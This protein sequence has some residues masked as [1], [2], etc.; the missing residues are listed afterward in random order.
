MPAA[1]ILHAEKG[2]DSNAIREQVR[3]CGAFANI[4]PKANRKW[5]NCFSPFLYKDRNAIERMFCRIKDFRRI[6]TRYDRLARNF[7][8]AGG[9]LAEAAATTANKRPGYGVCAIHDVTIS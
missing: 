4:P 6:A 7:L 8:A 1:P 2:Y 3:G 9:G 5:K